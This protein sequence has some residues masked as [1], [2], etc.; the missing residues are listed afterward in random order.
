MHFKK[1]I[2]S[3]MGLAVL[4]ALGCRVFAQTDDDAI[5][6]N[7]K[8]FCNGITYSNDHWNEYWEGEFK[9]SNAN[10]GTVRTQSAMFMTNYGITND[11]NVLA[12]VPYVWTH[13][14]AGTL[15]GQ[16][17]FQDLS[18]YVKWRAIKTPVGNNGRF[19]LFLVGGFSTPLTNYTI[20]FLPMS[21]GLGSTNLSGRLTADLQLGIFYL[22][23][24]SAYVWRSNVYLDRDSYY[25]TGIHY[26]NEVEMPDVLNSNANL[27]VRKKFWIAEVVLMNMTTLG[28]FDMRKNDMPFVSNKMNSTSLG[29]HGKYTLQ[30]FPPL[31]LVGGFDR[32]LLGR[33][34]GQ[35]WNFFGGLYYRFT[36]KSKTATKH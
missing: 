24:S 35:S 34:V 15:E 17:G 19:S 26:T 8:Q 1:Q 11:L 28:G 30:F 2:R 33:N 13:A 27:G 23:A 16:K 31:Q 12:S 7:K 21:I 10:I 20:D 6:M 14:S 9:R 4:L 25:T 32:V 3:I 36:F 18:L 5:M 22:T 29:L